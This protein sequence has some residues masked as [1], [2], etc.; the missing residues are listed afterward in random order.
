[1]VKLTKKVLI[2]LVEEVLNEQPPQPPKPS[3]A[4]GGGGEED[5]PK[6]LKIDIPDTPF[7]PDVS[8]IKDKLKH[9]LKQWEEK[10]YPSDEYRWK[11]Y[12]KDI[13]KL[14]RHLDGDK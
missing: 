12:Y 2:S 4:A 14:V 9:T 6:K 8:Q 11:S 7:E 5:K 3:P 10:Q 1:M 13:L